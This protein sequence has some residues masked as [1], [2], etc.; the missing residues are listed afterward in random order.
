MDVSTLYRQHASVALAHAVRIQG[1]APDAEGGVQ[2]TFL[3][4]SRRAHEPP[5]ERTSE[6][7]FIG[8][9]ARNR[10]LDRLRSSKRRG[11][12]LAK[13]AQPFEPSEVTHNALS[14]ARDAREVVHPEPQTH[15]FRA[16]WR[17]GLGGLS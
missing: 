7:A 13:V 2:E 14:E 1:G 3:E 15:I 11:Q 4:L 12:I 17:L 8:T 10:A 16:F 5:L 6:R 9:M